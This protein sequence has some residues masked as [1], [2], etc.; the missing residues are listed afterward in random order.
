MR[1]HWLQHVPFEG[2]GA[3]SS[4]IQERGYVPVCCRLYEEDPLPEVSDVDFLIVMGGPM[5]VNDEAVYP[6]LREEKQLIRETIGRGVPV[7]GTCLGAQLIASAMGARVHPAGEPEVG[8]FP[9]S[10]SIPGS[11]MLFPETLTVFQWHGETFEL[12]KGAVPLVSSPVCHNQAFLLG[13]NVIGMQFHLETTRESAMALIK[14]CPEDLQGDH[15][16]VQSPEEIIQK[17]EEFSSKAG[18]ELNRVL[19]VLVPDR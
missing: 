18:A 7:L 8:W 2:L 4:W 19:N 12:P 13:E 9:V 10:P 3:L 16:F 11:S 6:W 15:R 17:T 1:V 5:S 14:N